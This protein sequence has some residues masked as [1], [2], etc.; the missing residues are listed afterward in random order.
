MHELADR[1]SR[2]G[3]IV[4]GE[5]NR[6]G[7]RPTASAMPTPSLLRSLI[8]L[9]ACDD[10][11]RLLDDSI[12]L[13]EREL[14]VHAA[15]ELRDHDDT[16]FIRGDVPRE[17]AVHRTW[18]GIR[19]TIGAIYVHAPPREPADIELVATQVAPLAERL[20]DRDASQ[21]RTLQDDIKLLYERRIRDALLRHDWN[22][23]AVARELSIGRGRV[24]EVANR[25]RSR[26]EHPFHNRTSDVIA[27]NNSQ[28]TVQSNNDSILRT[29][30]RFL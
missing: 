25:W 23:S 29:S 12:T 21:R 3:R 4:R 1:R 16:R 17:Q 20:L 5:R 28:R 6:A 7:L 8:E 13:I 22:A 27:N 18:I 9:A 2:L 14:A 19:Y 11:D 24:A 15:I 10:L 30:T 26:A